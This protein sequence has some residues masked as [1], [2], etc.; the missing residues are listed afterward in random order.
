LASVS[1]SVPNMDKWA[2]LNRHLVLALNSRTIIV[3][4]AVGKFGGCQY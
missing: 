2:M 1:V 3:Y 4:A